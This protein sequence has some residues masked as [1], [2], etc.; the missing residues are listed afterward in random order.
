MT[1][2][3]RGRGIT[4]LAVGFLVLD[5]VMLF[6]AA[7]AGRSRG[8]AIGGMI[9]LVAAVAV[10]MMWQR[11]QRLVAEVQAARAEMAEE[12]RSLRALIQSDSKPS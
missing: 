2:P 3:V 6:A 7:A 10:L 5:G 4:R 12:A 9:C 1:R 11:Q 8:L